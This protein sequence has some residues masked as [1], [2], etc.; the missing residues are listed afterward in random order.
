[1]RKEA[2]LGE[3]SRANGDS[4]KGALGERSLGERSRAKGDSAKGA[5]AELN[6]ARFSI[7][8]SAAC[9]DG[10]CARVRA[11]LQAHHDGHGDVIRERADR[12]NKITY[13]RGTIC[14]DAHEWKG[15]CS[16]VKHNQP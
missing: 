14:D 15:Q 8:C 13:R 11:A 16:S 3:R 7:S 6:A 9:N 4:A 5:V 2:R 12:Y 10:K 1:M